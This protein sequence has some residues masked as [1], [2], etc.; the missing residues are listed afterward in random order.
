MGGTCPSVAHTLQ[1]S[2]GSVFLPT[3][4]ILAWDYGNKQEPIQEDELKCG[5]S[6]H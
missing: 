2:F 5:T 3:R 4:T 6:E 1:D